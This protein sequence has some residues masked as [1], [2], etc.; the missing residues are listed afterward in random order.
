MKASGH[1]FVITRIKKIG[2]EKMSSTQKIFL[3]APG[4]CGMNKCQKCNVRNAARNM[5]I[6]TAFLFPI[7]LRAG[8]VHTQTAR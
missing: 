8:T 3:V 2:M 5:T 1:F 6:L 4:F 7:A